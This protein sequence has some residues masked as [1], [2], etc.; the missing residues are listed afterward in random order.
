MSCAQGSQARLWVEPGASAHTFD[1]N[2]ERYE[3]LYETMSEQTSIIGGEGIRGTRSQHF[4][5]TRQGP[6]VVGGRLA[7]NISKAAL[8]LWLPRI[9]GAAESADTF[10]LDESLPSF[11]MLFDKVTQRYEFKDCKVNRAIF[12]GSMGE[13]GETQPI[14]MILEIMALTMVAGTSVPSPSADLTAQSPYVF[15]DSVLTLDSVAREVKQWAIMIDNRLQ[16]R[17]VNS[18]TATRLCPRSRGVGVQG[19]VPFDSATVGL[20]AIDAIAGTTGSLAMTNGS[21]TTTFTFPAL[22]Y[23][24]ST[25]IV[26]GKTEINLNLELLAR[27]TDASAELVVTNATS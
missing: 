20:S 1:E 5:T 12:R 3:F 26:R 4:N 21:D 18:L 9:L 23:I 14:E 11:G 2:S 25:P 16:P 27:R 8:D 19:A 6:K 10:N 22:Q 15:T 7:M 24:R 13:D 17:W